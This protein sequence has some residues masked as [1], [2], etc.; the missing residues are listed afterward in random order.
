MHCGHLWSST[1]F[2]QKFSKWQHV[3]TEDE[4]AYAVLCG[5]SGDDPESLAAMEEAAGLPAVGDQERL[6]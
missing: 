5:Q 6:G 1:L 4:A 2:V 3:F